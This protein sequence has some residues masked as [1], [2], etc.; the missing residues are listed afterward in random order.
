MEKLNGQISLPN[1]NMF[2]DWHLGHLVIAVCQLDM[3]DGKVTSP[4]ERIKRRGRKK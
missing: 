2:I 4:I 3:L 1:K